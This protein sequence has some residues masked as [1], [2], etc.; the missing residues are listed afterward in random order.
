MHLEQKVSEKQSYHRR[1]YRRIAKHLIDR[2]THCSEKQLRYI[3]TPHYL[4]TT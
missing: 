2:N 3:F 1:S 4:M